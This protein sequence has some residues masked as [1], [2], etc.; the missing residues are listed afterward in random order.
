VSPTPAD[1]RSLPRPTWRGV[2]PAITTPFDAQG[3]VDDAAVTARIARAID[4]GCSAIIPAGSLGEGNTLSAG[5]KRALFATSVEACAGRVPVIAAI[6]A[7]GT[8]EGVALAEAAREV[9][10]TG[11]MVLPPYV[12]SGDTREVLT[13]I[14]ALIRA[15]PLPCM[16]YNNPGAY[17]ADLRADALC[18]LA[19]AHANLEAVK[20]S[21]GDARRIT[22]IIE[23][24]GERLAVS[25][26]LDDVVV[27]G[28]RAGAVGWVAGL[29][30]AFP[31]ESVRLFEA[32]R[33]GDPEADA[34]YRWFLPLLRLDV[35]PDFVQRIKLV[36]ELLG[37]GSARVRPPRL[38]LPEEDATAV[39]RILETALAA[40]PPGS[41]RA[42]AGSAG[43]EAGA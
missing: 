31:V 29:V 43:E 41:A 32:A 10:C 25:A 4:A 30:N 23:R 39:Q 15:T 27:E 14:G 21:S 5:E 13:H 1:A 35:V 40:A 33:D 20:E 26:G 11:L 28:V 37:Q 19:E 7:A 17:G 22:A 12:H 6:A 24:A 9:G 42:G 36:E 3:R 34:L 16:V 2:M 38:P 18:S 8:A